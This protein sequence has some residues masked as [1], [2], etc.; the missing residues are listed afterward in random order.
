MASN[1]QIHPGD[2][3]IIKEARVEAFASWNLER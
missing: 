2:A 1:E 3:P